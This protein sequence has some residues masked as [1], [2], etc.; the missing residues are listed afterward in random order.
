MYVK[1]NIDL[2]Y[3]RASC[4][5]ET[6]AISTYAA[7]KLKQGETIEVTDES[8]KIMILHNLVQ[9]V[10]VPKI[11]N[12]WTKYM[13]IDPHE[14]NP[15]AVLWLAV[16]D[17]D[18]HWIYD[19]LWLPDMSVKDIAHAI[20]CQEGAMQSQVK[21]IDPHAD[22]ENVIAGGFNFR[23]ELMKYGVFTQRANSD[24]LL[25]K[26]KIKQALKL[27]YSHVLRREVP[28][29]HVSKDCKHTIYEFQHYI[30]DD[31]RRN[32]EE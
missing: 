3:Y 32:K 19:E 14:R 28:Q 22:K 27:N 12:H 13:A 25:D 8:A 9:K 21:L 17:K 5:A 4:L 2:G 1:K 20:L 6:Y 26:S 7:K 24:P 29:L 10:T 11:K 30:W 23:K 31:M 18:N 16:D 15:T